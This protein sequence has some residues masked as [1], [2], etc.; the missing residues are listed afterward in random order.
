[1]TSEHIREVIEF[2]DSESERNKTK[3]EIIEKFQKIGYLDQN[4]DYMPPYRNL[5]RWINECTRKAKEVQAAL[6]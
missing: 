1:M 5:G 6:T 3:E 4:G 2:M